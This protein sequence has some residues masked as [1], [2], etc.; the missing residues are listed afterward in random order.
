M[1]APAP[2]ARDRSATPRRPLAA[3]GDAKAG[4]NFQM[5]GHFRWRT[6]AQSGSAANRAQVGA[7]G[8]RTRF[9]LGNRDR[10]A[11]CARTRTQEGPHMP[12]TFTVRL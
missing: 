12:P 3:D 4:E 7:R 11:L 9:T 1:A 6:N 5:G 2:R 8:A 10:T